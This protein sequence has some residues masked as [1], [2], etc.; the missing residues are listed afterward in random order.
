MALPLFG[1]WLP[2]N[3]TLYIADVECPVLFSIVTD[4]CFMCNIALV[5]FL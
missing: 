2:H 5:T 1:T 4:H 3:W